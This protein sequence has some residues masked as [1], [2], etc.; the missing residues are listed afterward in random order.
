MRVV[1]AQTPSEFVVTQEPFNVNDPE[2]QMMQSLEVG[3]EH[4][5]HNGEHGVQ[6]VPL[7]KLPSGQTVP[8]DVTEGVAS[9][10]VR[11]L[12]SCVNPDLQVTHSPEPS[13]H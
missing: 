10:C 3:P 12:A 11:S 4:V 13:A 9:H 7:L 5:L 6:F 1:P 8:L 2:P